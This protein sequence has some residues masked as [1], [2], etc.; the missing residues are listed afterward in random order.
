MRAF[1]ACT[2]SA[3]VSVRRSFRCHRVK[4]EDTLTAALPRRA[5]LDFLAPADKMCENL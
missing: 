4:P 5:R 2:P 1:L 3:A